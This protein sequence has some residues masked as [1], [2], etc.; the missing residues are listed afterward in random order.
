M[1]IT[2][3][4]RV[5]TM[6]QMN[7]KQFNTDQLAGDSFWQSVFNPYLTVTSYKWDNMQIN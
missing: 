2:R 5:L 4:G 6:E 1:W 3:E 7:I